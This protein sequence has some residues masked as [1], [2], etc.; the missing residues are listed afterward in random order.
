MKPRWFQLVSHIGQFKTL[1]PDYSFPLNFTQKAEILNK[2]HKKMSQQVIDLNK[3]H[4][5]KMALD[6]GTNPIFAEM[7]RKFATGIM[8][9]LRK[10]LTNQSSMQVMDFGCGTGALSL[11]LLNEYG[12]SVECLDAVDVSEGMLK[13]FAEKKEKLV[14]EGMLNGNLLQIHNLNLT[15][16]DHAL[17][18]KKNSYDLIVSSMCFHH[19]PNIPE[20]LK[21]FASYLKPS[22]KLVFLDMD[23]DFPLIETFHP[24]NMGDELQYESGFS[25]AELREW[26]DLAGFE[27]HQFARNVTIEKKGWDDVMRS[28]TLMTTTSFKK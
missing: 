28:Y 23:K 9:E 18:G 7:S 15:T 5:D 2:S 4:F 27:N 24:R 25:E 3:Q 13:Q 26:L 1:N 16:D 12:Q 10:H 17:I 14:G 22:G 8:E 21:L 19:L 6:W 20:K 11:Y